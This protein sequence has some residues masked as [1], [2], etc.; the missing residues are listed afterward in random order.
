MISNNS[1]VLDK[2]VLFNLTKE[3]LQKQH[4]D[5]IIITIEN[6]SDINLLMPKRVVQ[7]LLKKV[8][9]FLTLHT[10]SLNKK[11]IVYLFKEE[12]NLQANEI[13][14]SWFCTKRLF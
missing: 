3:K 13:V 11:E 8:N 10:F 12:F 4:K 7:Y 5:V 1:S 9:G 6:E 14:K 2:K